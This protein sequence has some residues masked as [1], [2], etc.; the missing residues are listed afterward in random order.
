M[1]GIQFFAIIIGLVA[2]YLSFLHYKRKD[3]NK[4]ELVMWSMIW[5]ALIFV[6]FFPHMLDFVVDNFGFSRVMDFIMTVAFIILF[7]FSFHNYFIIHRIEKK[8]ERLVR[9]KALE[10]LER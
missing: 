5:F 6:S 7:S 1:I 10:D 9:S 8:I 3:F 4:I 2:L